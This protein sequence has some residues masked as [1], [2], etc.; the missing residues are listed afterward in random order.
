MPSQKV[1][2]SQDNAVYTTSTGAPVAQ[3]Y[4][5]ERIGNIGPLLLQG[6]LRSDPCYDAT[7]I[8]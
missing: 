2:K 7:D 4:A 1:F 5:A 3:P 8:Q 6:T